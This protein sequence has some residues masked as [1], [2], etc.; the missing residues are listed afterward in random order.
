[1]A[2]HDGTTWLIASGVDVTELKQAQATV[3]R[4]QEFYES[5][6]NNLPV[7]VVVF[8]AERH[9]QF[10][11]PS[12]EP[13][14]VIRRLA[15]GMTYAEFA[16]LYP[17]M[18][19][20]MLEQRQEYFTLA[21]RTQTDVSWEELSTDE[22][23]RQKMMLRHGRPVLAADGTLRMMVGSG[24]D[25][26]ARYV[27]ERLQQQAQELLQEQQAFIRLIVDTLPNVLYVTEPDGR[28]SFI[29]KAFDRLPIH[30]EPKPGGPAT[31]PR[32]LQTRQMR[33]WDQQVLASQ[34]PLTVELPVVVNTGETRHFQVHKRPLRRANGQVAVLTIS[35]DITALKQARQ[36]VEH[37]DRKYHD[38]VYY[39]QA[40]ICTHDL[41]GNLLSVNPA[42][43]RL[44]DLPAAQL[45]GHN[46]S[47][48]LPA[49]HHAA[50]QAY[51]L[52][53][54]T[55]PSHPREVKIVS[56]NGEKRYLRFY[57]F[58]VI[59]EGYPPYIVAS[60]YDVT[61]AVL[62]QRALQQAKLSAEEDAQAK[63]SFLARMSHEIRTPLN[64]VLGMAGLL[65]KTELNPAQHEYLNTMQHAGRHLLALLNDV[66]D[67]AKI[68]TQHLELDHAPF[69][70]AVALHGAGQTVAAMAAHKGL[71]F[72][73]E[74]LPLAAPRVVGDAYRLHQVLLNLLSNAIKFTATG[75][76]RLGTTMLHETPEA[77]TLRFWVEDTG[78][79]IRPEQQEHIFE[80]FAQA[81][82]E[83]SSR[84]GGTGLGLAISQQLVSQMGGVLRLCSEPGVGTTFA[85]QLTLPRVGTAAVEQ[86]APGEASYEELRGLRVLLAEDNVV[87]QW[88]A[89]VVLEHWGVLVQAVDN[90]IDALKRLSEE[91]YDVAILD[92]QMPG[93]SGV[94]VTQAIRR[95]PDAARAGI[96]IIALTAN[97][98]DADRAAYLAAG[99]NACLTKPYEDADLCGLLAQL[100]VGTGE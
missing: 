76:V 10:I 37:R 24:I 68:T 50:L 4:Q 55:L 87:N 29:N 18:P 81:S 88:I 92:I 74:P 64:G 33:G 71:Q 80:A 77:L 44:M 94:E 42:T 53:R 47:E 89:I 15:I 65:Q 3:V 16:E 59:E 22:R 21:A 86:A 97:A 82:A 54:E 75:S 30:E 19:A 25:I 38:L 17:Q 84:Y 96:P 57:T 7:D 23:Q 8:D 93:L 14:P 20:G 49:E 39:S 5:I 36:A 72:T 6:L 58:R 100:A 45:V 79:G 43:E 63:A 69:D 41:Q 27:A 90:G 46:L 12:A 70:L 34:R 11:N 35:T 91:P 31:P 48:F 60:G 95:H 13:N 67:M 56:R 40:L 99:M 52:D 28:I 26:T 51:L 83:T 1:V 98:F 66:L 62:A 78:A 9:L 85:F 32:H 61:E 73:V 2:G